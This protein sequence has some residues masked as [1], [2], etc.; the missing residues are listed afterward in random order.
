MLLC[1]NSV[2][3]M[4][5]TGPDI[6]ADFKLCSS[7]G[8]HRFLGT[9]TVPSNPG[10]FLGG[11]CG[12]C[13]TDCKASKRAIETRWQWRCVLSTKMMAY[14]VVPA[15]FVYDKFTQIANFKSDFNLRKSL[16]RTTLASGCFAQNVLGRQADQI[17]GKRYEQLAARNTHRRV[18]H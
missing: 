18:L 8:L 2:K 9:N 3:I 16:L 15:S 1:S 11:F 7:A 13:K 12:R 17:N 6:P 10:R 14:N 5:Y 4:Y